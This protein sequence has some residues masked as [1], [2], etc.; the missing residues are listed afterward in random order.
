MAGKGTFRWVATD[1]TLALEEGRRRLDLSPLG[2]VALGRALAGAVLL[3]RLS[4]KVPA[5]LTLEVRGDG[6]IGSIRAE[7]EHSGRVRGTVG[8]PR[9]EA[10]IGD[11]EIAGAVGKGSLFV[12][13]ETSGP[14]ASRYTSQVALVSGELGDDLTHYLEQSEQISSAVLLGVLPVPSGIAAAGGLA[15][16]A[17]P[18]TEDEDLQQLERNIHS[19]QGV[20][21]YLAEG[22]VAPLLAAVF[23]GFDLEYLDHQ[24]LEYAC[25]CNRTRLLEYLR[26][27]S[28]DDLEEMAAEDGGCEAICSYCGSRYQYDSEELLPGRA[29]DAAAG[30]DEV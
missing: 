28:P 26:R 3:Q 1:L 30:A 11:F 4:F 7:A 17:L 24:L 16:E 29:A 15:V 20:S 13:R 18:G 2:C 21:S 8:N 27:L 23:E 14:D 19:L 12:T 6:P 25:R 9:V 5:R 10:P 22:G